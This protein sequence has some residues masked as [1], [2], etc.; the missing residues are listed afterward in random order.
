MVMVVSTIMVM[1]IVMVTVWLC[2]LKESKVSRITQDSCL[3][4]KTHEAI[5]H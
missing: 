3:T 5:T 2:R 4:N 1:V